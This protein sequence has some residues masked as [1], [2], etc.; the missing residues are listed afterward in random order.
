MS[1]DESVVCHLLQHLLCNTSWNEEGNEISISPQAGEKFLFFRIDDQ[2]NEG[3]KECLGMNG[4][5][6]QICDLL[7]YYQKKANNNNRFIKVVCLAE[8][9]GKDISHAVDQIKN[10]F[11]VFNS[12]FSGVTWAAYVEIHQ[13]SSPRNVKK[14]KVELNSIGL[15]YCEI[16]KCKFQNFIRGINYSELT[17]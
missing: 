9:K 17:N 15:E 2:S 14:Q 4:N 12:K 8:G 16:G 5:N 11:R 3:L 13:K 1:V 6:Q 10:T 7:I